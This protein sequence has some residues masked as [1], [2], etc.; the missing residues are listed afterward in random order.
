MSR[1][2]HRR[3]RHRANQRTLERF[4]PIPRRRRKRRVAETPSSQA[5]EV[6]RWCGPR[7]LLS[8]K[9]L[10]WESSPT[11][12]GVPAV[13]RMYGAYERRRRML[14]L[15]SLTSFQV[16]RSNC[17]AVIPLLRQTSGEAGAP[18]TALRAVPLPR[19]RGG[20]KCA[21]SRDTYPSRV[22]SLAVCPATA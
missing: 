5:N 7:R 19:Y 21:A 17:A 18:S 22:A 9:A 15:R 1:R 6:H 8:P 3:V 13:I 16:K 14:T 10:P 20:G 11:E 4:G 12:V 2:K